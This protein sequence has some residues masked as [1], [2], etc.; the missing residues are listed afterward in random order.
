MSNVKV[1]RELHEQYTTLRQSNAVESI[2]LNSTAGAVLISNKSV[3]G[4]LLDTLIAETL[5]QLQK[6]MDI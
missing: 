2:Q 1:L 5:K 4:M 6:S 3:I